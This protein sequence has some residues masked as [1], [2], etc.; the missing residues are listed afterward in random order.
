MTGSQR[1]M[2]KI[3]IKPQDRTL[4]DHAALLLGKTP[5]DF[6]LEATR[7]AASNVL[8][9]RTGF[10]FKPKAYAAF[11]ARLDAPSK[12]N[13]RLRRSLQTPAPWG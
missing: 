10:A 1:N 13:K 6:V 4:I 7:H 11:L 5:T 2:L 8:S 12:P 3:R 9:D